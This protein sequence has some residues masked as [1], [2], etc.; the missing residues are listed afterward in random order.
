[1][2][3]LLASHSEI[4]LEEG[5]KQQ[6]SVNKGDDQNFALPGPLDSSLA[7]LRD[8]D[9]KLEPDQG[10]RLPYT[11]R[12]LIKYNEKKNSGSAHADM[13]TLDTFEAWYKEAGKSI[14]PWME[15]LQVA[16]WETPPKSTAKKPEETASLN[17]SLSPGSLMTED[18]ASRTL[19]SFDF[20]G[21]TSGDEIPLCINISEDNL[22]ALKHLEQRTA[23]MHPPAS[24][25][26]R[27]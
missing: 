12:Q 15:L 10:R 6:S 25:V 8:E 20:S 7:T 3:R 14:V 24:D 18:D 21:A 5:R 17:D 2:P 9:D 19:V 1:V 23:L 4:K 11:R 16:N 27:S 22:F 13:V 26:C